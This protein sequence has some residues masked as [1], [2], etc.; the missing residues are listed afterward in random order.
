MRIID[1]KTVARMDNMVIFTLNDSSEIE[2]EI[3]KNG[4]KGFQHCIWLN[5]LD[6]KEYAVSEAGT[7]F[8][9]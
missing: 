4:P 7:L 2:A 3:A 5:G 1:Y 8:E 6:G 9:I